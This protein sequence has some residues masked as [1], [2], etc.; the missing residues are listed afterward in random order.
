MA[1]LPHYH[2]H[3]RP[4]FDALADDVRGEVR[5]I[6][7]IAQ[8][9]RPG[10]AALVAGWQD[11]VELAGRVQ[12]VYV[13]HGAGQAYAG[14]PQSARLPGYSASGGHRHDGVIG[15]VSPNERVAARWTTAPAVAAGCAK[16]DQWVSRRTPSIY[17]VCF[18]WHWDGYE[19]CPEASSAWPHYSEEMP[20]LITHLELQGCKVFGHAHPRWR[21][22]LDERM[23][24]QG[25]HVLATE[26]EVFARCGTLFVDNSSLG[27]EFL[28]LNRQVV[29]MNAPWYRRD[30]DH[31]G[32]FWTWT[33]GVPTVDGPEEIL[34]LHVWKMAD[35]LTGAAGHVGATYANLGSA[36]RVA[37][38]WIADLIR[39]R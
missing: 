14:D 6:T 21:G 39:E 24:E 28:A 7:P 1:S 18:A 15:F 8:R 10:R 32:R 22:A 25:L 13:E 27:M 9:P 30:V 12:M 11:V 34:D 23:R 16:L 4:I 17:N 2:A 26:E 19:V 5:P 31:G 38:E 29:W 20:A 36:A 3:L 33:H 35:M 37:A